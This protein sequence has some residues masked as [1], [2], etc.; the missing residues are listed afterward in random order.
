MSQ[1][2]NYA[3]TALYPDQYRSVQKYLGRTI[4]A[5]KLYEEQ[6]SLKFADGGGITIWDSGQSCCEH[7][8]MTCDDDV[9]SLV[10]H[11]LMQITSRDGGMI[12]AGGEEHETQFVEVSTDIGSIALV[13][14]NEHNGYYGG[15]LLSIIEQEPANDNEDLGDQGC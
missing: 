15:F 14:H 10:G 11:K 13:N 4:S 7:R 12:E 3:L 5:A 6:L 9:Q 8:Y 1:G 2:I